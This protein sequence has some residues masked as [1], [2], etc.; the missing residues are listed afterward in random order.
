MN[1]RLVMTL[2]QYDKKRRYNEW[3]S[4]FQFEIEIWFQIYLDGLTF[5]MAGEV[6][7]HQVYE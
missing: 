6:S 4:E 2:L 1:N 7:V 5:N 3:N